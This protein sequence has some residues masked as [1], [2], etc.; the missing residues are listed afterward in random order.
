MLLGNG[1]GLAFRFG[2][3][4]FGR[5]FRRRCRL[6]GLVS[7]FGAG[8]FGCHVHVLSD[9]PCGPFVR[10]ECNTPKGHFQQNCLAAVRGRGIRTLGQ[11]G[12]HAF[13]E[14]YHPSTSE[15]GSW[16]RPLTHPARRHENQST[17]FRS[18]TNADRTCRCSTGRRIVRAPHARATT[19]RLGETT[20]AGQSQ[21]P[22]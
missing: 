6:C 17:A 7:N 20:R 11:H 5:S 19:G 21:G 14:A 1:F 16:F 3:S 8:A 4:G 15:L 2:R 12:K 10:L 18:R 9:W 22:A 13:A